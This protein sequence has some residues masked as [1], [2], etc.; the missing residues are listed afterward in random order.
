MH[1]DHRAT[2][3]LGS[4]LTCF[5]AE[6]AEAAYL[7]LLRS[8]T[9]GSWIDVKLDVWRGLAESVKRRLEQISTANRISDEI[10]P[11]R[12]A[13]LAELTD[14]AYRTGLRHGLQGSFLEVELE[15][16]QALGQV[17]ERLPAR[18][19]VAARLWRLRPGWHV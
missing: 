13:V 16:H 3:D 5:T 11:W 6:L 15:L 1:D 10:Q 7:V 9:C 18:H 4:L 19:A 12:E 2:A 8:G 17:I 14:A